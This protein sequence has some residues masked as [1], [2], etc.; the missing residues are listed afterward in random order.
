MSFCGRITRCLY[1]TAF[2]IVCQGNSTPGFVSFQTSA[3]GFSIRCCVSSIVACKNHS[4]D[5]LAIFKARRISDCSSCTQPSRNAIVAE[6][7]KI[8]KI[9]VAAA[10]NEILV[11]PEP[12]RFH[13]LFHG[14]YSLF[15]PLSGI[16]ITKQFH[17]QR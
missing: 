3:V 16:L 15:H 4:L 5:H 6:R 1:I 13:S 12:L 2:A 11:Q 8:N 7:L 9:V 10:K 17:Q 14:D